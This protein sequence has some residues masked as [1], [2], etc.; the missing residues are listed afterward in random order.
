MAS[1]VS[2]FIFILECFLN[3]DNDNHAAYHHARFLIAIVLFLQL[4]QLSQQIQNYSPVPRCRLFSFDWHL[5]FT[6]STAKLKLILLM[7]KQDKILSTSIIILD[8]CCCH[9]IPNNSFEF[10]IGLMQGDRM[11]TERIETHEITYT[12]QQ[13]HSV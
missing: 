2:F 9:D 1:T 8:V 5:L 13:V 11:K 12:A 3:K 7:T 10:W 4:S 6:V